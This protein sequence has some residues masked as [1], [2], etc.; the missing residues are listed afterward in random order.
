MLHSTSVKTRFLVSLGSN[1]IRSIIGLVSGVLIA[2]GLNPSG[3]GDLMFLLGSFVAIRSLLDMGSSNAFYTF[4][5]RH[6]QGHR[7]YLSYFAWLALQFVITLFFV[8]LII[9]DSV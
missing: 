1:S 7:F 5:S 3:Y 2:R 6:T 8:A 9:P 4:L